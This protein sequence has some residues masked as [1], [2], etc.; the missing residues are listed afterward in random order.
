VEVF[1][2]ERFDEG[3]VEKDEKEK[4]TRPRTYPGLISPQ[5]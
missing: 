1:R 4:E 5:P 2:I 3:D